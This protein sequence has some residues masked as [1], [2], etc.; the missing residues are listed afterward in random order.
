MTAG[1]VTA[2]RAERQAVPRARRPGVGTVLRWELRKLLAQ[3]RTFIGLGAVMA[4]PLIFVIAMSADDSGGPTDVPLGDA[5]RDTGLAVPLVVLFFGALWLFPLA[6]ALVAGDIVSSEEGHGTLKTIL[7]RSVDRWQIFAGKTLAA[8]G[9]SFV[10]VA[11][12]VLTALAAGGLAWGLDPLTTLSGTQVGTGRALL[13]TGA[14]ALAYCVP[15]AATAC[16]AILF[17]TVTRN[18]AAAIVATLMLSVVM[19]VLGSI[20]SLDWLDPYLLSS[21]FDSWQGFLREPIDWSPVVHS[22]WVS[23]LYGVPALA[24]ALAIFVRRDVTGG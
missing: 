15:I 13:L 21:Q 12:C 9:Y 1:A 2:A 4:V 8:L 3:K 5:V 16:L 11:A 22:L 19:Q 14:G 7:T 17:S 24:A 6:T 23:A 18:S 10:I 20:G